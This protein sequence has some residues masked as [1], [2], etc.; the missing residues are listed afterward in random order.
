MHD[1]YVISFNSTHH[2]IRFEKRLKELELN[3]KTIPT[4]RE[5]TS[6][7]GLSIMF[8]KDNIDTIKNNIDDLKIDYYGVFN[9]KKLDDG[10]K[11]LTKLY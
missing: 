7:C 6:S 10:N 8:Q 3:I 2:A 1:I 11:E 9:I 5:V 4:P